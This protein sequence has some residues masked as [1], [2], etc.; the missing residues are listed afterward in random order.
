MWCRLL[1]VG[2]GSAPAHVEERNGRLDKRVCEALQTAFGLRYS[3][4]DGDSAAEQTSF[5]MSRATVVF[6]NPGLCTLTRPSLPVTSRRSS[7]RKASTVAS[8]ASARL[9]SWKPLATLVAVTA[10][11]PASASF[12]PAPQSRIRSVPVLSHTWQTAASVAPPA[13]GLPAGSG[14]LGAVGFLKKEATL[15]HT[16]LRARATGS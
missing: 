7:G 15:R 9:R 14:P 4:M 16:S 8:G 13:R 12:W 10:C 3:S 1:C 6:V 5:E 2:R 11:G